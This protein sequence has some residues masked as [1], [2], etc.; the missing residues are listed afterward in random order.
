MIRVVLHGAGRMSQGVLA[1]VQKSPRF[2]LIAVV[3]RSEPV[4]LMAGLS[5]AIKPVH[6]PASIKWLTSLDDIE[7]DVDLLIDFTLPGGPATA[8]HW[9]QRHGVA[10]LSGT[11]GLS[12][13]D[14]NALRK[15]SAV[16]AVLWASNMS[17][18]IALISA[19][20]RQAA[21]SIGGISDITISETH[22]QHKLDAPSGTALTLAEAVTEGRVRST[23]DK[24]G[25][26][27]EIAFISVR[28][29]EVIGE[30]TISFELDGE[31]VE[32]SHKARDRSVFAKG[33][34]N[35]GAWL[36]SQKPGYY[37]TS[38]WL[39]FG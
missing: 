4:D 7:T 34:L 38:D 33:A 36:S 13:A 12:D 26:D 23:D 14:K 17:Q 2:E 1:E 3:S 19:L 35:A 9:C 31:I 25:A 10:L 20:A 32:I 18:G 22:H 21:A 24:T 37:A 11:T 30:H 8:A 39:N 15:A 27:G 6:S 28:K 29:G 5:A 16:V